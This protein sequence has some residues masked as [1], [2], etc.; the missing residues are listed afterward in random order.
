MTDDP[1]YAERLHHERVRAAMATMRRTVADLAEHYAEDFAESRRNR[2]PGDARP[3][4]NMGFAMAQYRAARL[5]DL[6]DRDLP[7]FFGRLWL[8]SGEDYHLGRRQ[9]RDE[10][11]RSVPLVVDWRAPL[12]ERFYRASPHHRLDVVRR[13]RFG[14]QG[15]NLTSLEDED[16]TTVADPGQ[17]AASGLLAAEIERPRTGPMRDIVATIQ[18]EQDELI[19]REAATTLCVQG[20]PGTGKTAVGLHRAAWLLYSYP[21]TVKRSGMLVVGP[22]ANFLSYIAGVLPTLGET[23][24]TQ[25]TAAELIGTEEA[26]G[27]DPTAVARLKHD[28]RMAEA[29]ERAVWTQLG[30]L[31]RDAP[32][33]HGGIPWILERDQVHHAL[34]QARTQ[35]RTWNPGRKAFEQAIVRAILRQA[36]D[37]TGRSKDSQWTKELRQQPVFKAFIDTLWPRLSAKQV[38]RRLYTDDAFRAQATDGLLAEAETELLRHKP[39][40]KHTPADLVLLDEIAAHL[41][42]PAIATTYSH[43]VVDEA[44]D[45]SPMECRAIARRCPNG[46]LTVLGDLA[47]GTTPWSATDWATQMRHL[48]RP[49]AEHTE[50]TTGYRVPAV[51]IDLANRLLPHLGVKVAPARSARPDGSVGLVETEDLATG[52]R[53]ALAK[54]LTEDGMIG[55]IAP[56]PLVEDLRD[57]VPTGGTVE[58]VPDRLA[59]GLEYDHVIV[60]EPAAFVES[61][62]DETG[63]RHLYVALTRAVSHLTVVHRQPLPT[64]LGLDGPPSESRHPAS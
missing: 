21:Q 49:G 61:G 41:G 16:L 14:F 39:G 52:V 36:E 31:D 48:G 58:L 34:E 7:L 59:K 60:V 12:A 51:I 53:E 17:T 27:V 56:E 46:S 33:P 15:S 11:D 37:R 19:R 23:S 28:A 5:D 29:C 8:E 26:R 64:Q 63:L 4:H 50:L 43:I 13:R 44:Q 35:G 1:L 18:P 2:R 20:A 6:V 24:V 45:L 9:V 10:N 62:H 55:V 32:I 38:L 25:L 3:D 22:N 47:Q 54:A 40:H 57:V 30:R 42:S